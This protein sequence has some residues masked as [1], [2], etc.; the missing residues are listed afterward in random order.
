MKCPLL[1]ITR[2]GLMTAEAHP[3]DECLK[4]ECGWWRK[5]VE[6]CSVKLIPLLLGGIGDSIQEQTDKMPPHIPKH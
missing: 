2:P 4:E 5:D 3:R 6:E 1:K